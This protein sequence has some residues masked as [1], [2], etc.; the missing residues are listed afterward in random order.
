MKGLGP[1]LMWLLVSALAAAPLIFFRSSTK[2]GSLIRLFSGLACLLLIFLFVSQEKSDRK[3]PSP[4]WFMASIPYFYAF[5]VQ[6]I[7]RKGLPIL[8]LILSAAAFAALH[9]ATGSASYAVL[10]AVVTMVFVCL[11]TSRVVPIKPVR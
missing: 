5:L 7:R 2:I 11:V 3:T 10:A 1:L 9:S 8:E 4:L 6:V